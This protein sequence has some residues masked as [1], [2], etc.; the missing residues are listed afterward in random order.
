MRLSRRLKK[1]RRI[2]GPRAPMVQNIETSKMKGALLNNKW[3]DGFGPNLS[4]A[5][6]R[7][8]GSAQRFQLENQVL[9]KDRA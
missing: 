5:C 8:F 2:F 9:Q 6:L 4:Q 1:V 3:M 7:S